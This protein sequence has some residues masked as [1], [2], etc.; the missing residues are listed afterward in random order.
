M[1][2]SR[3]GIDSI[4]VIDDDK[5]DF[6]LVVEALRDI[7]PTISVYFVDRCENAARYRNHSF[8]LILLDINMPHHDGF[9]WLKGIRANGY[10]SIPIIMYTNSLSPA[11]IVR[12]YTEGANLYFPKP[13]SFV[14]LKRAFQKLIQLDWGNPF[15]VREKYVQNGKYLT[16]R[17]E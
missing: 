6:E 14:T 3:R 7:D 1:E 2:I 10:D 17:A 4:L 8:D 9:S 12:S 5:D 16:F 13:E 11:D 15:S